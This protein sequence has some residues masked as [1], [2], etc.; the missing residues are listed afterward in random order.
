MVNPEGSSQFTRAAP[1]D[2]VTSVCFDEMYH[3]IFNEPDQEKVFA[4]L[5]NWLDQRF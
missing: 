5:K 3:E 2:M 1:V 4:T